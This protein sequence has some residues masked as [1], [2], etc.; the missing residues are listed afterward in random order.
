MNDQIRI[1]VRRIAREITAKTRK[2]SAWDGDE[3]RKRKRDEIIVKRNLQLHTLMQDRREFRSVFS[4][5][6]E[7][8]HETAASKPYQSSLK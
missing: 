4:S 7:E 1:T 6:V 3:R 8:P 2:P 5:P